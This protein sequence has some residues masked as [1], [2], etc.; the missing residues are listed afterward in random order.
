MSLFVKVDVEAGHRNLG[1]IST[2]PVDRL[3]IFTGSREE[4]FRL[5][6]EDADQF[7]IISITTWYGDP[8]V[9][10]TMEFE[11]L[12]VGMTHQ[13]GEFG[14]VTYLIQ[15]LLMFIVVRICNEATKMPRK[16]LIRCL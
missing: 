6:M 12:F 8:E 7:N 11:V 5:S 14:I 13:C 2:M 9:R 1:S 4:G 16:L 10:T 3:S 15:N